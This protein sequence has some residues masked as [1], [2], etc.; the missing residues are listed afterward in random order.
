[1]Q[2]ELLA[3]LVLTQRVLTLLMERLDEKNED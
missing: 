2:T 3:F 1:M